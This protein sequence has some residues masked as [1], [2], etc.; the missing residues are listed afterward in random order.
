MTAE[1]NPLPIDLDEKSKHG[2]H[3]FILIREAF[4][5][6]D[7]KRVV[8]HDTPRHIP[9]MNQTEIWCRSATW[10]MRLPAS[11]GDTRTLAQACPASSAASGLGIGTAY[12]GYS[13][14]MQGFEW[15]A[16]VISLGLRIV[17]SH[18]HLHQATGQGL[19]V[20]VLKQVQVS[21][22]HDLLD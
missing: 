4:H 6:R 22:S 12:L 10:K 14:R 2:I 18:A 9:G 8:F 17:G 1:S 5:A 16:F 21:P 19:R 20:M 15:V 3:Q 13:S 7:G 11:S